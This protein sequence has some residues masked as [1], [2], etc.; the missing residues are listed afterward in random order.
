MKLSF[1]PDVADDAEV[2]VEIIKETITEKESTLKAEITKIS[3]LG[4]VEV[5][6]NSAV[7]LPNS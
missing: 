2:D 3:E 1:T 4:V 6:F 5:E 7:E